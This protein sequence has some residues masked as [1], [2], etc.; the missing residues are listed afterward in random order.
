MRSLQGNLRPRPVQGLGLSFRC[1]DQTDE[2]KKFF[3]V[4]PFLAR[5][6]L[7]RIIKLAL[8]GL[9]LSF[10]LKQYRYSSFFVR[11]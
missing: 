9:S 8:A 7:Q 6:F 5:F 10:I 1:N 2:V 4:R 11:F 3:I